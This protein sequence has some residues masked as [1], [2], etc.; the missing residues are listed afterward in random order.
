MLII[1]NS[2]Y[3]HCLVAKLGRWDFPERYA[4]NP[5]S[6]KEGHY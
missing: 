2:S 4:V 5:I 6:L 3:K 1:G